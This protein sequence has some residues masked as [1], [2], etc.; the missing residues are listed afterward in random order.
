MLV[1]KKE[2]RIADEFR[3]LVE[4]PNNMTMPM[5]YGSNRENNNFNVL[6]WTFNFSISRN[7]LQLRPFIQIH[8]VDS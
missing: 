2:A 3:K 7:L 4:S 6:L 8:V 5:N 1:L